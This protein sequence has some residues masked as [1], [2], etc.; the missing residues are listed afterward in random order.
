MREGKRKKKRKR[1]FV[2]MLWLMIFSVGIWELTAC[3]GKKE[4]E[5]PASAESKNASVTGDSGGEQET[6]QTSSE[7]E[8]VGESDRQ[9]S[10]PGHDSVPET[11]EPDA[12]QQE[13]PDA[14]NTVSIEN[15]IVNGEW[16]KLKDVLNMQPTES[17]QFGETGEAFET[18][19]FYITWTNDMTEDD[20]A[21][22]MINSGNSSV[23]IYGVTVGDGIGT[24]DSAFE[25]NG[26]T[27]LDDGRQYIAVLNGR[28]LAIDFDLDENQVITGWYL[29]NWP[30]GD[31][32][33]NF[34]GL[35]NQQINGVPAKVNVYE[36]EYRYDL[37]RTGL[38]ITEYYTVIVE[39]VT[40]D[41]FDFTIYYVD[42]LAETRDVVFRT[43]TAVFEGDGTYAKYH[44]QE[45]ELEFTFP[46]KR[47]T[48]PDAVDMQIT[49]YEPVEGLT[50][51]NN[52]IPGHEF[53]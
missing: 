22:T 42:D 15:Y 8:T 45:Y 5:K 34:E 3:S 39:N 29:C 10:D 2:W 36:G 47:N 21:F 33:E 28:N 1:P 17:G 12:A 52:A 51:C 35:E 43:H 49:G 31:F 24:A 13:N 18:G 6:A 50:F 19:G 9:Q 44:G 38:P 4:D 23:N 16:K 46:D 40:E 53:S 25:E 14:G 11:E 20:G 48:Y 27:A 32:S 7:T 41:S 26:W 37:A 30:E